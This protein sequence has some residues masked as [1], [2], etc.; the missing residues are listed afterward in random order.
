MGTLNLLIS[1]QFPNCTEAIIDRQPE[2]DRLAGNMNIFGLWLL[3]ILLD[4]ARTEQ[5]SEPWICSV[6][7]NIIK[8][9]CLDAM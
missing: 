7:Q 3:R 4:N 1:T 8:Y 5:N 6:C 2:I 9:L